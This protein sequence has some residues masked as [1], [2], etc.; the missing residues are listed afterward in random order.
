MADP[1]L[2]A[3]LEACAQ[4]GCPLCRLAQSA[5]ARFLDNLFYE[6]VNDAGMRGQLRDSLGFCKTHTRLLL[7]TS[8]R[9]PLGLTIVYHDVLNAILLNLPRLDKAE[10]ATGVLDRLL[11][12][13]PEEAA[14]QAKSALQALTPRTPCPACDYRDQYT[15]SML[16]SLILHLETPDLS[17]ALEASHG[18]CLPH[19]RLALEKPISASRCA[20]LILIHQDKFLKLRDELAEFIRKSDY[21][22]LEEGFGVER[23]A[24]QRAMEMLAGSE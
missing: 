21:R 17:Q 12:R 1:N 20:K 6:M 22:F 16:E 8:L 5:T 10:R 13:P 14:E 18:L 23:N 3:I 19:L 11:R 2:P 7:D 4:P 15:L 24:Y 9:D